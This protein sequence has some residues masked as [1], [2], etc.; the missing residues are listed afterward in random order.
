MPTA[1]ARALCPTA[2]FVPGKRS[3]YRHYSAR[4]MGILSTVT[5]VLE[6]V[7]IDEA[8]LDVR[9][10]RRRLGSPAQIGARIRSQIRESIGLPAS[11]GVASTKSV[12]KIASSH[13]KPDGLLLVPQESTVE[14]LHGLPVGA[15][16]GVGGRTGA[17]LEREGIDTVGD[18]ARAPVARCAAV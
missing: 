17:A 12:A 9:G 15:L 13:A 7:S 1:R 2:A 10:A 8:F 16:W 11:V 3:L 18:L 14:F 5:P 6:Q 4:V